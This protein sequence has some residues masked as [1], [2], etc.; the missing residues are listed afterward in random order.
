MRGRPR[1]DDI[2]EGYRRLPTPWVHMWRGCAFPRRQSSTRTTLPCHQLFQW[3]IPIYSLAQVYNTITK[4]KRD[5]DGSHL[6]RHA[7]KWRDAARRLRMN[8]GALYTI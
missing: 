2:R 5:G 7:M 6:E 4:I 1:K 3:I 8:F